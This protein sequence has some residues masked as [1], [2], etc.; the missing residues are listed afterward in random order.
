MMMDIGGYGTSLSF[1]ICV[2]LIL[3]KSNLSLVLFSRFRHIILFRFRR[4]M[5]ENS[6]WGIWKF[7][8]V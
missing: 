6:L 2:G 4:N 7:I 5:K 1:S 8:N 3:R